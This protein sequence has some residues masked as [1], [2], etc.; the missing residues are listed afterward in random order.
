LRPR[1]V[2]D[3]PR[4]LEEYDKELRRK[5][6]CNL[7]EIAEDAAQADSTVR[8]TLKKTDAAVVPITSG[9][10][11]IKGFSEAVAAILNHIGTNAMITRGADVVGIAEA[12]EQG[13]DLLLFAD[14]KK[15]VAI[16]THTGRVVDNAPATAKAYV[17][18]LGR[19]ANGLTGKRVLVIGVGNVGTV[20]VSNLILRRAK[21]LAVDID[22]QKLKDL[23]ARFGRRVSIFHR[24][25]DALRT[26]NLI[27]NTAPVRN[28]IKA[29]MVGESTLISAPAIPIGLTQAVLRKIWHNVVHDSLQLGVA[30]MAVEA[31][32]N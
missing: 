32:V 4:T 18:A 9:G 3:I 20:A 23:K 13:A 21:P 25:S 27:V 22:M 7:L 14:D 2:V 8:R 31:C 5:T 1:D 6:G 19:M 24:T 28:L 10:G 29:N 17:A 26:T 30:T 11:V 16:N 15:F 12:Y